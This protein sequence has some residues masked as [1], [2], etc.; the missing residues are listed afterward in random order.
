MNHIMTFICPRWSYTSNLSEYE[1]ESII[2]YLNDASNSSEERND[3]WN[4]LADACH[5]LSLQINEHWLQDF[6]LSL[7]N[8]LAPLISDHP[9]TCEPTMPFTYCGNKSI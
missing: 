6:F 8:F 5:S 3:I 1:D 9:D 2:L 4:N 7:V